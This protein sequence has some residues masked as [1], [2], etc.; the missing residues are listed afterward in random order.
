MIQRRLQIGVCTCTLMVVWASICLSAAA[1]KNESDEFRSLM[2]QGFELHQ[3]ARFGEAI[4]ILDHARRLEPEDYF[5]NLLLGIDLLRSGRAEESLPRLEMAAR[6]KPKEE[7]PEEYLGEANAELGRYG[8]AAE[9]YERA[10]VRGHDSVEALEAWA[11]FALERFHQIG[12]GLRATQEGVAVARR[13]QEA[14]VHPNPN[15]ASGC[16]ASL[17]SLERKLAVKQAHLDA[18]AAYQL[19]ICYALEAGRAA[20]RLQAGA[21][22]MAAVHRLRG[23]VFLRLKGDAVAAEGEYRQAIALRPNDPG[24]LE[25]LAEAQL[26]AGEPAAAQESARASLAVDPHRREALRT[27]AALAMSDRDYDQALHWLRQLVAEAPGDRTAG[28]EL[29]KALAQTGESAE[30]LQRLAPAL[31]AGYPDEKG[32]LHALMA[33]MLR[34]LGRDGEALA[35][36]TEARRL[37]DAYQMRSRDSAPASPDADR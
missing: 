16:A 21:Q 19:S 24:L 33:R 4:P 25:S 20:E 9:A 18:G 7:F 15:H 17:A 32:A 12:E 26:S 5:A 30:S 22:D 37:S 35:A 1:Q 23:D 10:V 31:A 13:L 34:K 28:V 2:K 3:Q 8:L 11:G 6:A 36:E 29:A 14:A 27:L